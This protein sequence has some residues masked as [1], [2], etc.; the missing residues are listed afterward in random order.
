MPIDEE[1]WSHTA[2]KLVFDQQ[3]I[4]LAVWDNLEILLNTK[5]EY[6]SRRLQQQK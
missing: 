6:K 2:P 1:K 5:S 3:N 4:L